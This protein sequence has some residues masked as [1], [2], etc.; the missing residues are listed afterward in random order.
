MQGFY[1]TPTTNKQ[2]NNKNMQPT[3]FEGA[4]EIKKPSDM[5]DEQC[6]S[7]WAKYGFGKL[8]EII[9]L[10]NGG[11][12]VV[13]PIYAG[14]DTEKFPFYLTKWHLLMKIFRQ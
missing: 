13:P 11:V 12:Y 9:N 1:I 7:V 10:K 6:M 5:T 3:S 8:L 4:T 2:L 14:V